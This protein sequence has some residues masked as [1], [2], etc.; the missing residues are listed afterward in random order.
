MFLSAGY[1]EPL[2]LLLVIGFFLALRERRF[3]VAAVLAGLA[4]ATRSSGVMLM[5]V[6]VV[7]LFTPALIAGSK[8]SAAV[9]SG[10]PLSAVTTWL[11]LMC[12]FDVLFVT[13]GYLLFEHVILED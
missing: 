4:A 5:P 10:Q 1:T 6:L 11:K 12:A 8:A 3:F 13:A 9:L 7:P 2:A